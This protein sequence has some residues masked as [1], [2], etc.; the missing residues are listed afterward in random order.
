MTCWTHIL[1]HMCFLHWTLS[2]VEVDKASQENT[3][4]VTQHDLFEFEKMPFG[5]CNASA[6]FQHF[7]E[8]KLAG[9]ARKI[10]YVYLDD[11]LIIGRTLEECLENIARVLN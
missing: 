3:S 1:K 7:M 5:L 9:L 10:C 6:T 2:Q 4:F 11:N 8:T